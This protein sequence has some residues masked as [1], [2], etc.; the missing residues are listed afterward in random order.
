VSAYREMIRVALARAG[1][2]GMNPDHVEA[3]MRLEHGTLDA[4]SP[5]QFRA[6]V[7]T[8]AACVLASSDSDN[9]RLAWSFG[10]GPKPEGG[11][12]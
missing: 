4:L 11:N 5:A 6:E 7:E 10:L 1:R 12:K 3:Y 8:A 2:I 9:A